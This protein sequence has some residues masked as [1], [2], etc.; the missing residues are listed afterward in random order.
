MANTMD[1]REFH[2]IIIMQFIGNALDFDQ[3][4]MD[5]LKKSAYARP[6]SAMAYLDKFKRYLRE[7]ERRP[8]QKI[9]VELISAIFPGKH[10]KNVYMSG[11]L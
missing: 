10:S 5:L 2:D 9:P 6:E 11:M 8:D 3:E 7:M 1:Y 4:N